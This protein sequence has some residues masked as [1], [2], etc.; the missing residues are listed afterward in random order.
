MA[1]EK[2]QFKELVYGGNRGTPVGLSPW[3]EMVSDLWQSREL[4]IRLMIR[5]ISA[6]YRQS[7]L[8]YAWALI[9]PLVTVAIF[10]F[11]TNRRAL[12]IGGTPIPYPVFALWSLMVWQLFSGIL[13]G[14]TDSLTVAG[15]LVTKLNFTKESLVIAAL[16]QPLFEFAIKLLAFAIV[17]GIYSVIPSWSMLLIPLTLTPLLLLALG[18]GFILSVINLAARDTSNIVNMLV[19]IGMFATPVLYPPPVT[20]PFFL[21]N[22]LNPV[23]PLLIAT[24]DLVAY[25]ELRHPDIFLAGTIFSATLFIYGWR[26]FR[27]VMPRVAERA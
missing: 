9:L 23:S 10:T 13:T 24:Q 18:L 11:L 22:F 20:A 2:R 12:P 8:G 17:C 4:L 25:G 26:I 7:F 6:R 14:C 1:T 21:I 3:V 16:G 15:P 5:D 27:I 19:I